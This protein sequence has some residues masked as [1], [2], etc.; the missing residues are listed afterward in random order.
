MQGNKLNVL[1]YPMLSVHNI[2]SD[3][4]YIIIKQICNELLKTDNFN[5]ILLLD[6]KRPYVQGD[7]DKRVKIIRIPFPNSKKHQVIYFNPNILDKV[8]K[9]Y[10]IDIIWNNVVEQGHHFKYFQDIMIDHFRPK[11]FN[12]HHYV[13]HRSLDKI[14]YYNPCKHILLDQIMGSLVV[15]FNYFH[16]NYCY[17]MMLEEAKDVLNDHQIEKFKKISHIKLGGYS[18]KIK[19]KTKYDKFTFIYNHRLNG[20]KKWKTTFEIYDKLHS[21][22]YNFQ[23]LFT[24]GDKDNLSTLEKKPYVIIKSLRRHSDYLEELS[25]CHANMINSIHETYCIS[26][27]ESIMNDQIIIAPNRCTFP[28]LLDDSYPYLFDNVEEQEQ[29]LRNILDK[30][31]TEYKHKSKN[32]LLLTKHAEWIGEQ[33]KKLKETS[34]KDLIFNR[35]KKENSK[36]QIKQYIEKNKVTSIQEFR[37]FVYS[38]GYASQ[39]FPVQ[40]LQLLLQEFGYVYNLTYDKYERKR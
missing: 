11:V 28:E 8:F 1:I 13:I 36:Q 27:A 21:E 31:I 15:D 24:A 20:Y 3:S 37:K 33:F 38:L 25:K 39:S 34:E 6:N 2:N 12:Y 35:I 30:G 29:K 23:V 16:T 40:K 22:G 14:T 9:R 4:N 5:F 19:T 18:K 26:I 7:L 10:P 32:K 17:N